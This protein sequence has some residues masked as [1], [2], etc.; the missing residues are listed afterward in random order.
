MS[1]T[2]RRSQGSAGRSTR[3]SFPYLMNDRTS[4]VMAAELR[5]A[6]MYWASAVDAEVARM[7]PRVGGGGAR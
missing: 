3:S 7:Q 5:M 2:M 6:H 1:S 4:S